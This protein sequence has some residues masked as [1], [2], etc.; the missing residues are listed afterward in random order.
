M[1][2]LLALLTVCAADLFPVTGTVTNAITKSPIPHAYVYIYR[3]GGTRPSTPYITGPDG[4][5]SFN[6][7]GGSYALHAGIRGT[8]QNYGSNAS[9]STGRISQSMSLSIPLHLSPAS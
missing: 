9:T 2:T 1:I 6:L 5:F 4:R 7:P 3:T 8:I